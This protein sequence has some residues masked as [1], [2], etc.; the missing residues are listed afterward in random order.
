MNF[1]KALSVLLLLSAF[2][3]TAA[4]AMAQS[5]VPGQQEGYGGASLHNDSDWTSSLP[6]SD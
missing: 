2:V 1:K 3:F 4:A 5:D 6:S